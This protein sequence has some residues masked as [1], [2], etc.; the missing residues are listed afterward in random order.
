MIGEDISTQPTPAIL[1]VHEN[2]VLDVWFHTIT[3]SPRTPST[4]WGL[5]SR[6]A[7]LQA[8]PDCQPTDPRGPSPYASDTP[9]GAGSCIMPSIEFAR[10]PLRLHLLSIGRPSC[11]PASCQPRPPACTD[12][13]ALPRVSHGTVSGVL[14]CL[15]AAG[16]RHRRPVRRSDLVRFTLD[17]SGG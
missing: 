8:L 2:Q 1:G 10:L 9:Y 15:S 13:V 16:Y 17:G 6:P 5:T 3:L 11:P 7:V 4:S 12:P 14:P